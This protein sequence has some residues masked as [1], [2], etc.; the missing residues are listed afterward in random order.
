M[1]GIFSTPKP[2]QINL[3]EAPKEI[4]AQEEIKRKQEVLYQSLA[5]FASRSNQTGIDVLRGTNGTG[6]NL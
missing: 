2:P 6:T 4:D 3:P 5:R 1:A